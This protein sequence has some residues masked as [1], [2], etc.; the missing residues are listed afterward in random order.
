[1]KRTKEDAEL[2]KKHLLEIAFKELINSGF[3]NTGLEFISGK[4]G[5]TR[6]AVYWHFKNKD[7][8]LDSIIEYKDLESLKIA[9][10]IVNSKLEPFEKLKKLVGLNFPEL[11]SPLKEKKYVRMKVELYNYL[12]KKGDK[13]KVA[14]NFIKM[15]KDLLDE[16]KKRNE[17]KSG[18]D[19]ESTAH[20]ILSICA[21]TYIRF[22]S[23]PEKL[24]SI[25]NSKKIALDYLNLIHK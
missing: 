24:R 20:T 3:E 8:L 10:E 4:A 13:Q 2:T 16:C 6:G 5:V 11:D 9:A 12:N 25:G 23:V 1:M 21:G 22:N 14:E 15:C 18:I 17:L 7:D 19:T